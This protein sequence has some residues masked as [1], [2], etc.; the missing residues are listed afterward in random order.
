MAAP[1]SAD[2]WFP[3]LA[4]SNGLCPESMV[5]L[6]PGQIRSLRVTQEGEG[7]IGLSVREEQSREKPGL[8]CIKTKPTLGGLKF[9]LAAQTDKGQSGP[10]GILHQ[11][12]L[13]K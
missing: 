8:E 4:Y 13:I 7:R 6:P 11:H 1:S 9:P 2:R 10:D 5:V 12:F 3:E